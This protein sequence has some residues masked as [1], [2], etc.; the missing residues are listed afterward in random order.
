MQ[1]EDLKT[2]LEDLK[3]DL[4]D[5]SLQRTSPQPAEA[6][7]GVPSRHLPGVCPGPLSGMWRIREHQLSDPHWG[8]T[9]SSMKRKAEMLRLEEV[10]FYLFLC[11][12]RTSKT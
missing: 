2:D 1:V 8:G 9:D 4:E 5:D 3:A 12:F 11:I 7:R 6:A 10:N